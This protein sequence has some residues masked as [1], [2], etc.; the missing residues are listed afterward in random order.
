MAEKA[1]HAFGSTANVDAALA[2]NK[3]D[4]YDILF[5][6]GDTKPKVGWIDKN[7]QKVI[8]EGDKYVVPVEGESLPE[9][10]DEGVIYIFNDEGY[11]WNGIE[12]VSISKGADISAIEAE[13]A[14]K[15]DADTVSTMIQEASAIEVVEF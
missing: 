2:A 3:I 6:D 10:G 5:L 1:K 7:G 13:L 9:S 8:V 4:A 14:T 11:I 12:F 15:V